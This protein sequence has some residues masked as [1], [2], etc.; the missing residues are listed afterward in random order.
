MTFADRLKQ[1]QTE[2][3]KIQEQVA[4]K[5]GITKQQLSDYE[6]GRHEPG[7]TILI[8]IADYYHVSLDYLTGRTDRR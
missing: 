5:V 6:N 7:V 1:I 4:E 8:A 2:R 3:G